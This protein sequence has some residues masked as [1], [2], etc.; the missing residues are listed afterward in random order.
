MDIV[1]E[2]MKKAW[3]LREESPKHMKEL[4]GNFY[5]LANYFVNKAKISNYYKE[6]Y[7]QFA[8]M[9]ASNKAHLFDPTHINNEGKVSAVFSYFYKLIYLEIRYR[10][11]DTRQKK[12]RRPNTCS[13]E[14][15]S[16]V[17]EDQNSESN[18][19]SI[20]QE[21][22]EKFIIIAGRVFNKDEVVD[23]AKQ[24]RKLLNKA[25]KNTDF[26]PETSNEIVLEFYGKLKK[27]YDKEQVEKLEALTVSDA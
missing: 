13:Y 3:E 14:T 1:K 6:D 23:A 21:D 25:K 20:S 24:A 8:V 16:A 18:I 9:R 12:E 26:V 19:V 4:V 17:I 2:D 15:I 22:E 7:V 11:R 27:D 10:M 5:E